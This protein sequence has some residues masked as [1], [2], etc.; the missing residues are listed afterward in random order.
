MSAPVYFYH[1]TRS[2]LEVTLAVL[3]AKSLEAGWRVA[4]RGT[5][6]ERLAWLDEQLWLMGEES[7]LPHGL[8]GGPHDAEQPVLLT[9]QSSAPN[10]AQALIAI[11]SAEVAPEELAGLARASIVFDGADPVAVEAA[12]GQWR[13]LVAAGARAVYWSQESGAWQKKAESGG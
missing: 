10:G 1:L 7:F 9:T 12:R 4:L 2:P 3:L 8:A 6:P 11:D 13:A 5:D